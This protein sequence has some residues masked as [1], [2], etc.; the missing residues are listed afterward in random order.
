MPLRHL[1]GSPQLLSCI[2]AVHRVHEI[3]DDYIHPQRCTFI[4]IT[5]LVIVDGNEPDTQQRKNL[6][7][8]PLQ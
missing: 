2:P 8:P 4:I 7:H 3:A 1:I 6:F 5:V